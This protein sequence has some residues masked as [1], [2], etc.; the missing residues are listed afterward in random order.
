MPYN[1]SEF[2]LPQVSFSY[3]DKIL[4]LLTLAGA[5]GGIFKARPKIESTKILTTYIDYSTNELVEEK[6]YQFS[7]G[8]ILWGRIF[9][10]KVKLP[11]LSRESTFQILYKPSISPKQT[12]PKDTYE[13]VEKGSTRIITLTDKKCFDEAETN[14]VYIETVT[15]LENKNYRTKIH[16]TPQRNL[17]EVSNDNYTEIRNYPV[18]LPPDFDVSELV[19]LFNYSSEIIYPKPGDAGG[20]KVMVKIPA[21]QANTPGRITIMLRRQ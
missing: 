14:C 11:K 13:V 15:P 20:I 3:I 6:E 19:F 18:E 2:N 5:I 21:K 4:G 12:L 9:Q 7:W 17:I 8:R 1:L 16:H 10:Q